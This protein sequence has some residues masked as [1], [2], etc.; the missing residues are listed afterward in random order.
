MK[1]KNPNFI[2]YNHNP[3]NKKVGDCVIRAIGK[4]LNL[5]WEH[6]FEDL[7]RTAREQK[8]TP[9]YKDVYEE[10]L[11]LYPTYPVFYFDN[12]KMKKRLTANDICKL[13]GS[14]IIRQAN[15]LTCI[16]DGKIYDLFDCGNRSSYKIW[17][18]K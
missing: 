18:V 2:E 1:T 3:K 7:V 14:Y 15:H 16:V 6:T 12:N 4:A 11:K 8:S 10:Y 5:S 17:K 13:K 9:S